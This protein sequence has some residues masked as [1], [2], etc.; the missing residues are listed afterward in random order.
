M[1]PVEKDM[2]LVRDT[3]TASAQKILQDTVNKTSDATEQVALLSDFDL[4][5]SEANG[6]TMDTDTF[7]SSEWYL[8]S[9]SK[10]GRHKGST[11]VLKQENNQDLVDANNFCDV[12]FLKLKKNK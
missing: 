1:A 6:S 11:S 3:M 12:A 5:G 8:P 9:S 2:Q 7:A 4:M 10:G